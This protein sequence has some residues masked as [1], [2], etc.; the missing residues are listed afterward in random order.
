MV[1]ACQSLNLGLYTRLQSMHEQFAK[2]V[3]NAG[4]TLVYCMYQ[5][6]ESYYVSYL[7]KITSNTRPYDQTVA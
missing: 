3:A 6:T 7:P 5:W 4:V 2:I 1:T